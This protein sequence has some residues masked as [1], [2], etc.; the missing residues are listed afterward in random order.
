MPA[1]FVMYGPSI[2]VDMKPI[3]QTFQEMAKKEQQELV[4]DIKKKNLLLVQE[5]NPDLQTKLNQLVVA[6]L[7]PKSEQKE[8]MKS[9]TKNMPFYGFLQHGES[10]M[11]LQVLLES[12]H[13]LQFSISVE[14]IVKSVYLNYTQ[15][16]SQN[17]DPKPADISKFAGKDDRI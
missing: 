16:L 7:P 8:L 3:D 4:E 10:S 5:E 1:N 13:Y 15:R 14:D 12:G 9:I 2:K 11:L 17:F 6:N